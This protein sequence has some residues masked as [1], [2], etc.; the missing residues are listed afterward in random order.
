[1]GMWDLGVMVSLQDYL[2]QQAKVNAKYGA[3]A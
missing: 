3:T 2:N 1:M